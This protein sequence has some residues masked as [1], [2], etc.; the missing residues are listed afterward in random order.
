MCDFF[1]IDDLRIKKLLEPW[2]DKHSR[3]FPVLSEPLIRS[4]VISSA[5]KGTNLENQLQNFF[6][7]KDL[8]KF[9]HKYKRALRKFS[10]QDVDVFSSMKRRKSPPREVREIHQEKR[11]NKFP[12]NE[13]K[14]Q[15]FVTKKLEKPQ[16]Y[17]P[18]QTKSNVIQQKKEQKKAEN[19]FYFLSSDVMSLRKADQKLKPLLFNDFGQR[20][21]EDG[22]LMKDEFVHKKLVVN[23]DKNKTKTLFDKRIPFVV[24]PV[25]RDFKFIQPG[26]IV[27]E[28]EEKRSEVAID[29]SVIAGLSIFDKIA[30][31]RNFEKPEIDWW[32]LPYVQL[33]E[34][35]RPVTDENNN[36][37]ANYDT[38]DNEYENAAPIPVH[39]SVQKEMPT[40]LTPKERKRLKHINKLKK[41]NEERLMIKLNLKEKEP[42][43]I[44]MSQMIKLNGGKSIL[45]PTEVEMEIRKNKEARIQKHIENNESSKLTI[46]QKHEKNVQKRK[47]DSEDNIT[48]SVFAIKNLKN[49]LHFASLT[50]MAQK[51]FITG[52]IF[53]V[54]HPEMSFVVIEAGPKGT[55]KY[56]S[57]V[58][59]R[60]KWNIE[61]NCEAK[62][63]FQGSIASRNFYNFKKYVFDV[64]T[65]CRKFFIK[66][67][68]E[69]FFN[70]ACQN[71]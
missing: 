17:L 46:E 66:N 35:Q 70:S 41:Q 42:Q 63:T 47:D 62:M 1:A 28:I 2:I 49:P 51:W 48:A 30:L 50:N 21:D 25:S 56:C 14:R 12:F 40:I 9:I 23:N 43:R 61:E 7:S 60:I 65:Q 44:K 8:K 53:I 55:R 29:L 52:G 45:S 15:I 39:K 5:K 59:Q 36:W 71:F 13:T 67:G 58:N 54:K 26:S 68:C 22:N 4:I 19:P 33:D 10:A 31:S 24:K 32:D 3:K 18:P 11:D 37:I 34:N 20:V 27:N 38:I 64:G 69:G 6:S 16:I 57:L